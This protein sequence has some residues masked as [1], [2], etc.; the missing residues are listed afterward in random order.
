MWG[1]TF[2]FAIPPFGACKLV[3][4]S[5]F[6][7]KHFASSP[8]HRPSSQMRHLTSSTNLA[9]KSSRAS[10]PKKSRGGQHPL[11]TPP[12]DRHSVLLVLASVSL[13]SFE[14][15]GAG[16]AESG[17]PDKQPR[18][19]RRWPSLAICRCGLVSPLSLTL[20]RCCLRVL[21]QAALADAQRC[22][23]RLA[24]TGNAGVLALDW[25]GRSPVRMV[26]EAGGEVAF[27]LAIVVAKL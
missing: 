4:V 12:L 16:F 27:S 21:D 14:G 6:L 8:A 18:L 25:C 20:A 26:V 15:V 1:A 22:S 17:R 11:K 24:F 10:Q 23:A 3:G 2:N 5:G 19:D 13:L 7:M 9:S